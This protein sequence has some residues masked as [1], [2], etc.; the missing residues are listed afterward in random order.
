[1][2]DDN[3]AYDGA[4]LTRR[5]EELRG[6][7]ERYQAIVT[8]WDA[9]L[10]AEGIGATMML[11]L[12][13]KQLRE[14]LDEAVAKRQLAPPPAPWWVVGEA[15]GRAMLAEL[16]GWVE[17]FARR[18]Y[19]GYMARLPRCWANHPEAVW[20]L[21]TLRAEWER[22]YADPDNRDLA[23]ALVWHDKFFPGVL[24][25]LKDSIRCDQAGCR[26]ARRLPPA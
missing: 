7:V 2:T 22:I 26:M 3:E 11:R 25:R 12:E 16:R 10:E 21:S 23:G 13:V 19:P 4:A 17:E 1:V 15:E 24:S 6:V 18:H 14:R 8:T 9:R 20:E 5:V